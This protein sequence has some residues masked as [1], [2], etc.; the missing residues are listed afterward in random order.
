MGFDGSKKWRQSSNVAS[1]QI[2]DEQLLVPIRHSPDE[3]V[4]VYALNPSA[5]C[6]WETLKDGATLDDLVKAMCARFEVDEAQAR[7]DAQTCCE[8]LLSM[9]AIEAVETP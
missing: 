3:P 6:I 1:R 5:A 8:D 2:G 4:G 9:D 7:A